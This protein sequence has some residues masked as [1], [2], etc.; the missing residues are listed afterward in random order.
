MGVVLHKPY[1]QKMQTRKQQRCGMKTA[2]TFHTR[3]RSGGKWVIRYS[4]ASLPGCCAPSHHRLWKHTTAAQIVRI[5]YRVDQKLSK[6]FQSGQHLHGCCRFERADY[7]YIKSI[8]SVMRCRRHS[9]QRWISTS[10]NPTERSPRH[11]TTVSSSDCSLS[12]HRNYK[13]HP[14]DTD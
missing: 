11:P 2:R 10:Q 1:R 12:S 13:P 7:M 8:F 4:A 14:S 9:K 6:C 3:R 5:Q